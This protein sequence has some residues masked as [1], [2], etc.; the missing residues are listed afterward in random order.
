M[1]AGQLGRRV[2]IQQRSTTKDAYGQQSTT[3][4]DL[5]D[6]WADVKPLNARELM[7]AQSVQSSITHSITLRYQPRLADPQ[8]VAALRIKLVKDNVT[9]YFNITGS[10]DDHEERHMLVLDAVEGL[11]NG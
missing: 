5:L 11:S 2:T 1:L 4:D 7:A 9:R 8:I 6:V 3:W 10:R